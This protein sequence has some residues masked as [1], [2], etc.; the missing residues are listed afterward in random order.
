MGAQVKG[1][2]VS[3]GRPQGVV[4]SGL[5]ENQE[6]RSVPG[7]HAHRV[8]LW[9]AVRVHVCNVNNERAGWVR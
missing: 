9:L 6:M 3:R 5:N 4:N 8:V 1:V 7:S 2:G